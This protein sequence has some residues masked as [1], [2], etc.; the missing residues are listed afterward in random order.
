VIE[1]ITYEAA[2]SLIAAEKKI[3]SQFSTFTQA[4]SSFVPPQANGT[5]AFDT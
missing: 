4:M 3:T 1:N 2:P 5:M